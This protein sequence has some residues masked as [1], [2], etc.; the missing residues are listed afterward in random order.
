MAAMERE[1]GDFTTDEAASALQWWA[2]AGVD[3]IVGD[4]PRDWLKPAPAPAPAPAAGAAE[5]PAARAAAVEQEMPDTLEAFRAW[6]AESD[7]IPFAAPSAPRIGPSGDPAAGLVVLLGIPSLEDCTAGRLLS[8]EAGL[9]FD[10]MLAAIGRDRASVWLAPLSP[11]RPPAGALD[12][13]SEARLA[14]I[15][16]H[17]LGLIAPQAALLF[18]DAP[19]RALLG[20]AAA[21]QARGRWHSIPTPAGD[22]KAVATLS[23]D[24]LLRNPGLKARAWADLQLLMEGLSP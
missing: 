15:A 6:L 20:G 5:A 22:V 13:D 24:T 4:H 21:A 14:R 10:R 9:L 18:G 19:A 16:R 8:G 12:A 11:I 3:T 17:H 2:D 1:P 23:P 7:A